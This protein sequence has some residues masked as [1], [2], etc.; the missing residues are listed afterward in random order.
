MDDN[1]KIRPLEKGDLNEDYFKVLSGLTIS[2]FP[3][4]EKLLERFEFIQKRP[5][6]Y[7]V[8]V[9]VNKE[10]GK[11]VGTG[12]LAIEHKFIRDLGKVGHIEDIV[13]AEDVQGL[14]I[15]KLVI[16]ALVKHALEEGCYKTILACSEANVSFYVKCGFEKKEVEMAFY[17]KK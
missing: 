15:G 7:L 2:P 12:T 14:G 8:V 5:E 6:T 11:V 3:D 4:K 16:Q 9:A 10:T 1:F 17:S 13:M